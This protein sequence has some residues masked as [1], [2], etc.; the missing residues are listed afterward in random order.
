MNLEEKYIDYLLD[1]VN[2]KLR[3]EYSII[4]DLNYIL[5]DFERFQVMIK[6]NNKIR[7]DIKKV[8]LSKNIN[9]KKIKNDYYLKLNRNRVMKLIP[10]IRLFIKIQ[11]KNF[12]NKFV[13]EQLDFFRFEFNSIKLAMLS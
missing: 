7:S 6:G 9:F 8:I 11:E 4:E 12:E 1:E 2:K 10:I 13:K 3:M 5:N